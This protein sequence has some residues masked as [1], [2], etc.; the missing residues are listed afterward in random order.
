M[1]SIH[2]LKNSERSQDTPKFNIFVHFGLGKL[3]KSI[4]IL[5]IKKKKSETFFWPNILV[6][7]YL[8]C[9]VAYIENYEDAES[10]NT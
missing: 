3:Y 6:E 5:Q 7:R 9:N 4:Q 8:I 10:G 1:I 2:K